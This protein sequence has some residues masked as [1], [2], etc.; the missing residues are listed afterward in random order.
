[1]IKI[2][3]DAEEQRSNNRGFLG[4]WLSYNYQTKEHVISHHKPLAGQVEFSIDN[5]LEITGRTQCDLF[6]TV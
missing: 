5:F 4:I 2:I 3:Q 1:M 6:F